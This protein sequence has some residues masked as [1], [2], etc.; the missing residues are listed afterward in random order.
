MEMNY[1]DLITQ[2]FEGVYIVDSKR[3]IL[4]WNGG[5]EAL[6]GYKREEVVNKYCFHNILDHV[7]EN[8]VN[9]CHNGC[10]LHKTLETGE[11]QENNVF[12]RHKKGHRVPVSIRTMPLFD[13][14]G[15]ITAA[16][17]VFHDNRMHDDV[18][19]ENRRLQ[20]MLIKD[21][22]TDDYNRRYIKHQIQAMIHEYDTFQSS[23][24]ILFIDID[25]F[26]QVNDTY[27][28]NIGDQVLKTVAATIQNTIRKD[29][30][31]GRW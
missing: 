27:G 1:N 14:N 30:I 29:D 23:F 17:E 26:K 6:T 7:D 13:P 5:S 31:L 12:L 11:I 20:L 21:E 16:I 8:G 25:H 18:M 3:K 9:L 19:T 28:H 24:A 4:F 15:N 22:L 2:L 10:P